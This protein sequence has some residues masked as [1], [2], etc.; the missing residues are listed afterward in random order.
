MFSYLF[1]KRIVFVHRNFVL[2][3]V[4]DNSDLFVTTFL[5]FRVLQHLLGFDFAHVGGGVVGGR[6]PLDA[7][8][9]ELVRVID[10]P[11]AEFLPDVGR[12]ELHRARLLEVAVLGRLQDLASLGVVHPRFGEEG[13]QC[14]GVAVAVG[15]AVVL[16]RPD[17]LVDDAHAVPRRPVDLLPLLAVV[18]PDAVRVLLVEF[19]GVNVAARELASEESDGVLKREA[20]ALEEKA[21]LKSRSVLEVVRGVQGRLH[22]PHTQRE[23]VLFGHWFYHF[24]FDRGFAFFPIVISAC[25]AAVELSDHL[26]NALVLGQARQYLFVYEI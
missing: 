22:G 14:L 8:A 23:V 11:R 10:Q 16:A 26:N 4:L 24:W 21:V 6:R 5:N 25:V 17:A 9:A 18:V 20:D 13:A 1:A 3:S 2:I 19:V 12:F 15:A 7:L